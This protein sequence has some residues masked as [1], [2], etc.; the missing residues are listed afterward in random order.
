MFALGVSQLMDQPVNNEEDQYGDQ[1]LFSDDE[2]IEEN[3]ALFQQISRDCT[4][5]KTQDSTN[6]AARCY[7]RWACQKNNENIPPYFIQ[8]RE[9]PSRINYVLSLFFVEV[10]DSDGHPYKSTTLYSLATGLNRDFK[11]YHAG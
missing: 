6:W 4:P 2:D 3:L 1:S 7:N 9:N 5:Q 8:L 11:E 10:V